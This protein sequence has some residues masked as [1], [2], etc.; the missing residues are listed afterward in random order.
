MN[1]FKLIPVYLSFLLLAAH[2]LRSGWLPAVLLAILFP[3]ILLV[4]RKWSARAVQAILVL[5]SLEWIRTLILILAQR[6]EAGEPWA[7]MASILG[8]VALFTASSALLFLCR[9]LKERY[10]L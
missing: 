3:F 8:C 9:S 2:F 5:A 4:R 1:F 6:R 7:R 10:R